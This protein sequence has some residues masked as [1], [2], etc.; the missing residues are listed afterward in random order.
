MMTNLRHFR[1]HKHTPT[2]AH[3]NKHN[4]QKHTHSHT[5][6]LTHVHQHTKTPTHQRTN[7]HTHTPTHVQLQ[8]M[9]LWA[10]TSSHSLSFLLCARPRC[11]GIHQCLH[12]L[13]LLG[14]VMLEA[15]V[16]H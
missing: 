12:F 6:T 4:T 10:D 14:P 9:L 11:R 7:T 3:S 8:R 1:A 16:L 2:L 5:R 15:L 13:G